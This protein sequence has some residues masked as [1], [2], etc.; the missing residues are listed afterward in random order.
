[1]S[2]L[3]GGSVLPFLRLLLI[4]AL[5][6]LL[7]VGTGCDSQS[8][9][10]DDTP[11]PPV[12]SLAEPA[13]GADDVGD[14]VAL[15][16]AEMAAGTTFDVVVALD[17]SFDRIFYRTERHPDNVIPVL[18]L[19][20]GTPYYWRVRAVNA[21][22]MSDW[23]AVWTFTPSHKADIAPAPKLEWPPHDALLDLGVRV[24]WARVPG[25]LSYDLQVAQED[26]FVRYDV[27]AE[28]LEAN[29]LQLGNLIRGY[30]YFWRVRSRN[31]AGVSEWSPSQRFQIGWSW[32]F[33]GE[34]G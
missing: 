6:V 33:P 31:A 30:E 24:Q 21:S 17:P 3:P 25:A 16:W 10:T 5:A 22:G 2:M 18:G 7:A 1:M 26:V 9:L 8:S 4:P 14:D 19:Q 32:D 20:I 12:P 28:G 23:T 34:T 29:T 11:P 13:Y 15:I 27:D